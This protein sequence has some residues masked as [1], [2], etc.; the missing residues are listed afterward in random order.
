[1]EKQVQKQVGIREEGSSQVICQNDAIEHRVPLDSK[2]F[3]GTSGLADPKNWMLL[4]QLPLTTTQ[5]IFNGP[6]FFVSVC[7]ASKSWKGMTYWLNINHWSN[8]SL[9]G[10]GKPS[11]YF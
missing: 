7:V 6:C 10:V 1:M 9:G 2:Y 11:K 5:L 3:P 8:S 4:L